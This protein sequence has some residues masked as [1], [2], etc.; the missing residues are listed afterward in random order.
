ME[1]NMKNLY[2]YVCVCVYVCVCITESLYCIAEIR[3]NIVHQ[4]YLNKNLNNILIL[5]LQNYYYLVEI[6]SW[7]FLTVGEKMQTLKC[8]NFRP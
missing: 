6:I 7:A 2:I 5:E 4:L 8:E 3:H 1:R